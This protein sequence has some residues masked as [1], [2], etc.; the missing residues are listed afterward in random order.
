MDILRL[1]GLNVSYN[2][3]RFSFIFKG[4]ILVIILFTPA[5]KQEIKAKQLM[6][7]GS[8]EVEIKTIT[9]KSVIGCYIAHIVPQ[10]Q[11]WHSA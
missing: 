8:N 9:K 10:K 4:T 11:Q 6:V 5:I 2:S 7:I 3:I 1:T